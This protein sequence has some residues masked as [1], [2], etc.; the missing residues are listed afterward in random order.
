MTKKTPKA[1]Y[2]SEIAGAM[3]ET[4]S[5]MHRLGLVDKKTMRDFDACC[6][7]VVDELTPADIAGMRE[8]A[9][10][11]QAVFARVLNVTADYVSKLERGAKRPSG[12]ALKL[13]LLMRRKG[14]EAI[15]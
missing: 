14:F 8:E 15:L 5:G 12:P 3:H 13:L 7:T 6:L 11:S 1:K 9:G 4:V 10:V 2:R